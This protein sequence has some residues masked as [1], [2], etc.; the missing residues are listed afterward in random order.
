MLGLNVVDV[1]HQRQGR[2]GERRPGDALLWV[3]RDELG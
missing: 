1:R 2:L 3:L